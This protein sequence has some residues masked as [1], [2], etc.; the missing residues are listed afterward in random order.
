MR[1]PFFS[2]LAFFSIFFISCLSESEPAP[3][4]CSESDLVLNLKS[5]TD[6]TCKDLGTIEVIATGGEDADYS[7]KLNGSGKQSSPIFTGLS[8]GAYELSVTNRKTCTAVL[9]VTLPIPDGGVSATLVSKKDA[10]CGGALGEIEVS[11]TGGAGGYTFSLGN[12]APQTE[13]IFTALNAGEYQIMVK[14]SEQCVTT[15]DA[16][17][18]NGVRLSDDIVP[19]IDANCAVSGCHDGSQSPLFTVSS[20]IQSNASRIKSLTGS[21]AMPPSGEPDLTAQQIKLI[22][23]WADDVALSN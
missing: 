15:V 23:C 3:V 22:A 8:A 1:I 12:N 13:A 11:A 4:D 14:D 5:K 10:G 7:Y 21:G 16:V 9:S 20:N 6:P 18:N 19:I 17:V 2:V